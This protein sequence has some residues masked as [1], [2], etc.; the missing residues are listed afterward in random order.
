[1]DI[2]TKLVK[3]SF[4]FDKKFG[5]TKSFTHICWKF[6][7]WPFLTS[8]PF[9]N[10]LEWL[11]HLILS[12]VERHAIGCWSVG[13]CV[14]ILH[15]GSLQIGRTKC[16][17]SLTG[18]HSRQQYRRTCGG[19][20]Q[21]T[22]VLFERYAKNGRLGAQEFVVQ[23]HVLMQ[24]VIGLFGQQGLVAYELSVVRR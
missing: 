24:N 17:A 14:R 10:W 7:E 6:F 19:N 13:G 22:N 1:M 23:L 18:H 9:G 11:L 3:S 5:V 8:R 21:I 16:C 15:C 2:R 12:F 4:S 20:Q